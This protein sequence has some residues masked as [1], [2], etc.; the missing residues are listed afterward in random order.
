MSA[1]Q[2]EL[3]KE[4]DAKKQKELLK[5]KYDE[6]KAKL[7]AN[8]WTIKK[9]T[10]NLTGET[11][12]DSEECKKLKAE[13]DLLAGVVDDLKAYDSNSPESPMEFLKKRQNNGS[14][15]QDDSDEED[16]G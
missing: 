4:P 6:K 1:L 7:N 9:F 8:T 15:K 10:D 16:E 13:N 2:T 3:E 11:S 14:S 5:K 12:P